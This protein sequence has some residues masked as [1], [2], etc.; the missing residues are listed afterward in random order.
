MNDLLQLKKSFQNN[1]AA[2]SC[3]FQ[4]F[5]LLLSTINVSFIILTL[6]LNMHNSC[7]FLKVIHLLVSSRPKATFTN[8]DLYGKFNLL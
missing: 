3:H 2:G 8:C 6:Y 7:F 1:S 4:Y 5:L